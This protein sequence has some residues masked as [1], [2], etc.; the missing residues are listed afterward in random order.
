MLNRASPPQGVDSAAREC[1][2]RACGHCAGWTS[3]IRRLSI[4]IF[5]PG[6]S[7]NR[8]PNGLSSVGKVYAY[9]K[10]MKPAVFIERDGILNKP[11]IERQQQVTPLTCNQ[12]QLNTEVA[13]LLNEMKASGLMLIVT[14]NQPGLSR[15]YQS[16]G[17]LDRMHRLLRSTFAVDDLMVC[18]HEDADR[19]PCRKPK[20]GLLLEASY[21]W[22]VDLNRSFVISD[23]W[24]DAEAA[25]RA[26]ATS[27]LVQS[28]WLGDGHHDF[29]MPDLSSLVEKVL[30]LASPYS[31]APA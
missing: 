8:D 16:R 30:Q 11:L 9:L 13:P 15:G 4:G 5:L 1:V 18:P 27:L 28:P 3:C 14:T 20:P 29:V 26:G 22:R 6:R 7:Q 19:C 17:E 10:T 31:L 23:K 25:R 12:F 24:Q 2:R 21:K